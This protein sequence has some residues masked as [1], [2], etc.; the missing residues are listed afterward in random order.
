MTTADQ[1]LAL[2]SRHQGWSARQLADHLGCGP[3]QVRT[4]L[5]RGQKTL[6]NKRRVR[7]GDDWERQA[8]LDAYRDGEKLEVIALEFDISISAI[9]KI[10]RA[11]GEPPRKQPNGARYANGKSK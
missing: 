9:S 11:S 1:I 4:A 5:R 6:T 2:H 10:A 7:R 8:I 3:T